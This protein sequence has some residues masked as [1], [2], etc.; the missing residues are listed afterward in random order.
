MN[1]ARQFHTATRIR[2]GKILVT[3]GVGDDSIAKASAE[4]YDPA[5][6]TWSYTGSLNTGRARH[7][8]TLRT[9][10]KVLVTG[11]D[12]GDGV[13][14]Y[15]SAEL[16]NP[17]TGTWS[18][19]DDMGFEGP[20][21][22]ALLLTGDVLVANG[23]RAVDY[24]TGRHQFVHAATPYPNLGSE[25][26]TLLYDGR[27]LMSG[28]KNSDGSY[29]NWWQLYDPTSRAWVIFPSNPMSGAHSGHTSTRRRDSTV[30]ICGGLG[31][32]GQPSALTDLFFP[33]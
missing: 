5:T 27:V 8:A 10:G 19:T 20:S 1:E 31:A 14:F 12:S 16:Y 30:L 9:D 21:S 11:G 13:T 6:A 4:I 7:S 33:Y 2:G 25:R 22:A 3:G 17:N 18:Y 28:G 24:Q 32:D 29:S 23:R 15:S 26:L